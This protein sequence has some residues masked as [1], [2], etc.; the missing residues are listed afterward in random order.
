MDIKFNYLYRREYKYITLD[1]SPLFI[2]KLYL[3][4]LKVTGKLGEG[5]VSIVLECENNSE[6][7]ALIV[8]KNQE[9]DYETKLG[10]DYDKIKMMQ[11]EGIINYDY[12]IRTYDSI[13]INGRLTDDE[14]YCP[15]I[16]QYT[17]EI[18]VQEKGDITL[19]EFIHKSK[20]LTTDE[21]FRIIIELRTRLQAMLTYINSK[22]LRYTDFHMGNLMFMD[23]NNINSLLFIDISGFQESIFLDSRT[24]YTILNNFMLIIITYQYFD[25]EETY[26]ENK[27]WNV[28][29]GISINREESM[30]LNDMYREFISK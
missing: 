18:G 16:E 21:K 19:S 26:R 10:I 23:R 25:E 9:C 12:V 1:I 29:S 6:K 28:S 27:N 22:K 5:N 13:S 4:G 14:R 2:R 24:V 15:S 17:I 20:N 11:D 30:I 3:L 7:Y 8:P